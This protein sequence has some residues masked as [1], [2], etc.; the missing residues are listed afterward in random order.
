MMFIEKV[1]LVLLGALAGGIVTHILSS[2]RQRQNQRYL[3]E[4]E[5]KQKEAQEEERRKASAPNEIQQDILKAC[6]TTGDSRFNCQFSSG[7]AFI[8]GTELL[9][10]EG[11]GYNA[12]VIRSQLHDMESKGLIEILHEGNSSVLFEVTDLGRSFT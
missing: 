7:G 4:K 3:E 1:A 5:R 11:G 8:N 12:P 9:T 2:R 6:R 10:K